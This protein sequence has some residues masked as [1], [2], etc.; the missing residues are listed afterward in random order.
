MEYDIQVKG[1]LP[2]KVINRKRLLNDEVVYFIQLCNPEPRGID[3]LKQL[4][5]RTAI[6]N[7][8]LLSLTT[9]GKGKTFSTNENT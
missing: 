1:I 8:A 7:D 9:I 4:L 2:F 5:W 6:I 3:I